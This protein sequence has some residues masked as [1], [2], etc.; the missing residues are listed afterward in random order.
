MGG[1]VVASSLCT[2]L[3]CNC[4]HAHSDS[5]CCTHI[6][7]AAHSYTFMSIVVINHNC[8]GRGLSNEAR[9]ELLPKKSR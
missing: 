1:D 9:C 7:V 8:N 4:T 5:Y 2:I 6:V 3:S